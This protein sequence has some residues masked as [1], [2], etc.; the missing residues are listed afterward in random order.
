ME[1]TQKDVMTEYCTGLCDAM[2]NKT[3]ISIN[4][5]VLNKLV[6]YALCDRLCC[7][8]YCFITHLY[9]IHKM[10]IQRHLFKYLISILIILNN[11]FHYD[12]FIHSYK[13]YL[14]FSFP[15]DFLPSL[16]RLMSSFIFSSSPC[17]CLCLLYVTQ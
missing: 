9:M 7:V 1:K 17:Q 4:K 13:V 8:F 5:T 6:L 16:T 14:P 15:A 2:R 11:R 10:F 12:I 3:A